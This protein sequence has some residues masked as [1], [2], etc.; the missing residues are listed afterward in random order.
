LPSPR[1]GEVRQIAL[2]YDADVALAIFLYC[3]HFHYTRLSTRRLW[4]EDSFAS[5]DCQ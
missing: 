1:S 4:F 3:S 5:I 2:H